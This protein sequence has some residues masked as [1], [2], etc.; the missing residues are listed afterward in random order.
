[1]FAIASQAGAIQN[2]KASMPKVEDGLESQ[3]GY[4]FSVSGPGEDAR[5][6]CPRIAP[7]YL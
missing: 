7:E 6:R 1:L 5:H 4:I 2:A 3:F